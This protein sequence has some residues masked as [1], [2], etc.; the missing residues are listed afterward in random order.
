MSSALTSTQ[1]V[2]FL[3]T[4]KTVALETI[5]L[6][7][8]GPGQVLIKNTAVAQNP[9]DS[10][11]GQYAIQLTH[12]AG[13]KVITTAS[14]KHHALVKSLIAAVAVDYRAPDVVEQIIA[15]SGRGGID[16][17]HSER[18]DARKIALVIPLDVTN[19]DQTVDYHLVMPGAFLDY[20]FVLAGEYFPRNKALLNL[21]FDL[22]DN[23]AGWFRG[24]RLKPNPV[25]VRPR[26]LSGIP[27]GL[28]FMKA[29]K[30]SRT[31]LV[32][33]VADTPA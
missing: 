1:R 3:Q 28:K 20:E 15:A 23:A 18:M 2:I 29:G 8:P 21:A 25:T 32:Y 33:R 11:V 12:I 10:S 9:S 13:Y 27:A 31:K 5:P 22:F 16:F 30:V 24:G 19:L 6:D 7:K 14:P 4:D 17:V 26:G